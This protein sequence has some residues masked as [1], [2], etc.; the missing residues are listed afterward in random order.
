MPKAI[1]EFQLP[2][3]CE[4]F[5]M[6]LNASKY[7]CAIHDIKNYMRE[8]TKYDER[9]SVPKDEIVDKIH[10]LISNLPE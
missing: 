3:D 2:E 7:Y 10:D 8:L 5:N 4:D 6:T 1:L 9:E